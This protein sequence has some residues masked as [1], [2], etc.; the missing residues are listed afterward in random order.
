M[1]YILLKIMMNLNMQMTLALNGSR[2]SY[3]R[4]EMRYGEDHLTQIH[5]AQESRKSCLRTCSHSLPNTWHILT[6]SA[7]L[8]ITL[9]S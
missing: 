3:L 1:Q 9:T 4:K 8:M 2:K 5:L 6:T 7:H